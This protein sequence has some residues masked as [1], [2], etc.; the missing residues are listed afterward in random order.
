MHKVMVPL[1]S[2][3][4]TAQSAPLGIQSI[5][6]SLYANIIVTSLHRIT[7]ISPFFFK[8]TDAH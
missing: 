3:G 8:R 5:H 6:V 4:G 1:D 2:E 7:F